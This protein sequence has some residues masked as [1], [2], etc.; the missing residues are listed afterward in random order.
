MR[1]IHLKNS[2]IGIFAVA[3]I[4]KIHIFIQIE[5]IQFFSTKFRLFVTVCRYGICWILS[6]FE[7]VKMLNLSVGKA[8]K[9]E[10]YHTFMPCSNP[11]KILL[12]SILLEVSREESS[13]EKEGCKSF[14]YFLHNEEVAQPSPSS[15]GHNFRSHGQIQ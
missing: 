14:L 6:H 12:H 7:I 9:R 3:K 5:Q 2:L 8:I 4:T 1:E 10:F 15:V 13:E 11:H